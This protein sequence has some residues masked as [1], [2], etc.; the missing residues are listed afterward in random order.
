MRKPVPG[1]VY[2]E[3]NECGNS[4]HEKSRDCLSPSGDYCECEEFVHPS[5]HEEHPE[6]PTDRS[7][8]L[9]KE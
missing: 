5:S 7:G 3:C 4:W 1:M 9:I 8:N 6:W 2:Y